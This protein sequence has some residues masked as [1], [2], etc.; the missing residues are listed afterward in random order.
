MSERGGIEQSGDQALVVPR[1]GIGE[2]TLRTSSVSADPFGAEVGATFQRDGS[3]QTCI[4]PGF[5][6]GDGIYRVRFSP[7]EIGRWHYSVD[8]GALPLQGAL[9]GEIECIPSDRR[10]PLVRA[11]EPHHLQYA[12]GERVFVLGNTAYNLVTTYQRAPGEARAFVHYYARRHFNWFRF[13]LQQTTWDSHGRVV[14]PWGGAP[15]APDFDTFDLGTFRAAEAVITLLDQA[16][17][18]ASV[19]LLHPM[20]AV[21]KGRNDVLSLFRRYFRYAVARLG[22]FSNVVWNIANEWERGRTLTTDD[23]ESLG[24]YLSD[25]NPF[26]RLTAVHHYG[27]FEFPTSP[28]VSLSSLQHRGLPQEINRV[29]IVNRFFGKPVLNEEYGYERDPLRPPNDPVNVRRDHWALTMAGAY[30]TYGDKTKGPKVGAY[31]SSTLA[32]SVDAQVPDVLAHLPVLMRRVPFWQMAPMNEIVVEGLPEE[33]FCLAKPGERY[34]VYLTVGQRVGLNLSHVTSHVLYG[35][36][37]NPRTGEVSPPFEQ[38]RFEG[39]R[40][41]NSAAPNTPVAFDPPDF[42]HDWVL[43]VCVSPFD[44]AGE[45]EKQ[46]GKPFDIAPA[47]AALL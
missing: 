46:G 37:W 33:V 38:P 14:W 42:E 15:E 11:A 25:V 4:V 3:T 1:F 45:R 12:S 36:W 31:F 20:D 23:I 44:E 28:W 35:E 32:D 39:E 41:I 29:A 2:L 40:K 34:L 10:G 22:A 8:S 16:G 43:H 18:T 47:L 30:G 7:P 21:F 19:I 26:G 17:C 24:Q 6:D 27:R 13:F 5:Y 9:S